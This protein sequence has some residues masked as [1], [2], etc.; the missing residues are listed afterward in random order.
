MYR[1]TEPKVG[2]LKTMECSFSCDPK[3]RPTG[4]ATASSRNKH[5]NSSNSCHLSQHVCCQPCFQSSRICPRIRHHLPRRIDRNQLSFTSSLRLC[6]STG[7]LLT[8]T[9]SYPAQIS[10]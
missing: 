2:F 6:P 8:R 9:I 7:D 3:S 1:S 4:T 5:Q 10:H